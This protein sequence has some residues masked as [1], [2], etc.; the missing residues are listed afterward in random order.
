MADFGYDVADFC[1]VDPLFGDLAAFDRLLAEAHDLGIRVVVDL[2][3]NH[4]SDQHP[5]F[6]A[7]RR[8]PGRPEAGLVRLA[9]RGPATAR[10]RTTGWA[11][12]I[13]GPAWTLGRPPP[14]SGTS[15]SSS[16]SNRT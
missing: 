15:T 14:S 5:W 13:E 4:T 2:V 9:G 6:Q 8:Q 16:R 12:F 10:R 7:A 1:D 3:P 11:A